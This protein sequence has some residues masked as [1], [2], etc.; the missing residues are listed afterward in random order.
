MK[1]TILPSYYGENTTHLV[2]VMK[3]CDTTRTDYA[4]MNASLFIVCVL[5]P[6]LYCY[7]LVDATSMCAVII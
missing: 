5:L 4:E 6:N 2:V 3:K 1:E 7:C